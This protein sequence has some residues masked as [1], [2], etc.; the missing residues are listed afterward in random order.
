MYRVTNTAIISSYP[1]ITLL[2][3]L[4]HIKLKSIFSKSIF[5]NISGTKDERQLYIARKKLFIMS[6]LATYLKISEI[7][8]VDILLNN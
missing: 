4:I 2:P 6:A 8:E 5:I 1:Y 3:K 7:G